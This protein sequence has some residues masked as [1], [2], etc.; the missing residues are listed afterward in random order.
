MLIVRQQ[1]RRGG[2]LGGVQFLQAGFV[3]KHRPAEFL[4]INAWL[5]KHLEH[6]GAFAGAELLFEALRMALDVCNAG[7]DVRQREAGIR[8]GRCLA[9]EAL[10]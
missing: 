2:I 5:G 10:S 7:G 4:Q 8:F 9:A 6:A 1:L 3:I